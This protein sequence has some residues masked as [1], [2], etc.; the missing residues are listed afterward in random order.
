MREEQ[1]RYAFWSGPRMTVLLLTLGLFS[2]VLGGIVWR[3]FHLPWK[4]GMIHGFGLWACLTTIGYITY[5]ILTRRKV[6]KKN[7]SGLNTQFRQGDLLFQKIEKWDDTGRQ[8]KLKPSRDNV[9]AAGEATGHN[10]VLEVDEKTDSLA[11]L[12]FSESDVAV[13]EVEEGEA[14]VTHQEHDTMT[15]DEGTWVVIRQVE[16]QPGN[17]WRQVAD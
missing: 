1:W 15:L 4:D 16:H 13:I 2:I 5:L 14:Q 6:M 11:T 10:H 3:I 9:I 7:E 17:Q 12:F 8:G